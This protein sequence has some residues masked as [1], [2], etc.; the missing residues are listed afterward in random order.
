MKLGYTMVAALLATQLVATPSW[1]NGPAGARGAKPGMARATLVETVSVGEHSVQQSLNLVGKLEASESVV[2]SPE[3]AGRIN[4]ILVKNNQPVKQDQVLVVLDTTKAEMVMQEAKLTLEEEQRILGEFER[5]AEKKAVTQTAF[6]GQRAKVE[7]AEVKLASAQKVY[8]DLHIKAPFDGTTGFIN[9]SRG[10]MVSTS[11][12]LFTI[13]DLSVMYLDVHVSEKYLQQL[14]DQV[15][16]VATSQAWP[17]VEFF[18]RL[19]AVD[20]RIN[21]ETLNMTVRVEFDNPQAQL[22]PGMLMNVALDFAPVIEPIIPVQ[23]LVYSG[24]KRFVYVVGAD[25]KV[26]RTEV[27]LGAR[28]DDQVVVASGLNIGENIVYKGTV[29][30]RDGITVQDVNAAKS[31]GERSAHS[32]P[33]QADQK[34]ARGDS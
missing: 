4:S 32:K 1:A 12:E 25:N 23:S 21:P 13:D 14:N 15:N 10:K 6:A 7:I 3:S 2:V 34:P 29:N 28:F 26:V 22:K 9:F 18:G 20:T 8:D 11:S 31:V 19:S 24:S 5:L 33:D 27:K 16:I 17:G 30:M